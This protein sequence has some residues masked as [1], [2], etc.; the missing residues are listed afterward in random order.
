MLGTRG[1]NVSSP[2]APVLLEPTGEMKEED[3]GQG[4]ESLPVQGPRPQA[5]KSLGFLTDFRLQNKLK[6]EQEV[7]NIF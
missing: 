2:H 7:Y 3:Q 4:R 1:S 6:T 5:K